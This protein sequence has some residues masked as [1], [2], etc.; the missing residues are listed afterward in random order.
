VRSEINRRSKCAMAP[1]TWNTSSPAALD[2][3]SFSSRLIR[4]MPRELF[5]GEY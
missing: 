1:N 5:L 2:V 3:S 4:L